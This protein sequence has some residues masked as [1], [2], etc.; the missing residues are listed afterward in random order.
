MGLFVIS[1]LD[2]EHFKGQKGQ[3]MLDVGLSNAL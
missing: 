3:E 2:Y 1:K